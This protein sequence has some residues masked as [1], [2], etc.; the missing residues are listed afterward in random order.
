MVADLEEEEKVGDCGERIRDAR[1]IQGPITTPFVLDCLQ[2][3]FSLKR[4][5]VLISARAIA[6]HNVM[7]Q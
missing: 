4:R 1:L 7:L 6:N 5:L 3:A 2:S